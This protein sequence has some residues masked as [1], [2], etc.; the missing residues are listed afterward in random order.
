M[1]LNKRHLKLINEAYLIAT[2]VIP[3]GNA[4]VAAILTKRN[5]ILSYG[6]NSSKTNP[7][8]AKFSRNPDAVMLHAET[9]AIRN[10]LKKYELDEL[11]G[12][13]M[14]VA[15]A[16]KI[17]THDHNYTFGMAKPCAGCQRA[18]TLFGIKKVYHTGDTHFCVEY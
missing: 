14:Y 11:E 6:I 15:R 2:D 7:F 1:T 10:A 9:A 12:T 17:S 13:T 4:R 8:A 18:L 16:R 5:E 3:V